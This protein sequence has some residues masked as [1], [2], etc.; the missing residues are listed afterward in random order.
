MKSIQVGVGGLLVFVFSL[1]GCI[2]PTGYHGNPAYSS[3]SAS[4]TSIKPLIVA[5]PGA[6]TY[7]SA[8]AV[9]LIC[10]TGGADIYYTT[11]GTN[12]TTSG[13]RTLYSTVVSITTST[14]LKAIATKKGMESSAVMTVAYT[15]T[16]P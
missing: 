12:P 14:S 4:T 16:S 13:T 15:I 10:T 3:T 7:P 5:S 8:L 2:E 11:D 1:A 6:G 9:T